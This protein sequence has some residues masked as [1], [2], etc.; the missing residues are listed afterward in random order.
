MAYVVA[1]QTIKCFLVRT[2]NKLLQEIRGED[3]LWSGYIFIYKSNVIMYQVGR[4][5]FIDE[6]C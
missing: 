4:L 1:P 6:R 2:W 5:Q 3:D